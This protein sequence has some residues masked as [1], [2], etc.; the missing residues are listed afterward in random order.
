MMFLGTSE[1]FRVKSIGFNL[2]K[3]VAGMLIV[4]TSPDTS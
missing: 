4:T 2:D 1:A 3:T